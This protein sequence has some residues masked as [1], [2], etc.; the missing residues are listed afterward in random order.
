MLISIIKV[1]FFLAIAL[2]LITGFLTY[3]PKK[4]RS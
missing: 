4:K 2:S 1:L 3:K